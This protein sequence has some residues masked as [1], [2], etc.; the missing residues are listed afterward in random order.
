MVSCLPAYQRMGRQRY[1]MSSTLV[2][3]VRLHQDICVDANWKRHDKH[4]QAWFR[5]TCMLL[6]AQAWSGSRAASSVSLCILASSCC[7]LLGC[8]SERNS[9]V[10]RIYDGRGDEK[11]LVSIEKLHRSP[12]HLMTVCLVPSNPGQRIQSSLVQRPI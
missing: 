1:S 9:G 4:A 12:V 10:I 8:S 7:L 2:R 11:P 6:G 5:A 3:V